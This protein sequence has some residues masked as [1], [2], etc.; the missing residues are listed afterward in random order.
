MSVCVVVQCLADDCRY[1]LPWYRVREVDSLLLARGDV[2]GSPS[3]RQSCPLQTSFLLRKKGRRDR[4]ITQEEPPVSKEISRRVGRVGVRTKDL[5]SV[6]VVLEVKRRVPRESSGVSLPL[7]W[8]LGIKFVE[9]F[10]KGKYISLHP[11]Y[12]CKML[13]PFYH[14]FYPSFSWLTDGRSLYQSISSRPV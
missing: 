7:D 11:S 2:S 1:S 3:T 13:P 8:G 4:R 14:V 10:C 5:R 12:D 9:L 6:R